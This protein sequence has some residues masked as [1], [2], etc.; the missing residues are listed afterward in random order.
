MKTDITKKQM[1]TCIKWNGKGGEQG[2][3]LLQSMGFFRIGTFA[4]VVVAAMAVLLAAGRSESKTM[5]ASNTGEVYKYYTSI[6]VSG[7]DS[8]WS[9][10]SEYMNTGYADMNTCIEEIK[11]LNHLGD[12]EIHAGEYLMI[13]YYSDE[14][15]ED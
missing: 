1:T 13:P 9:I 4:L 8:L 14:Y 12:D 15:K 3:R 10:A 6:R 5:A 2:S 7:G 11:Q